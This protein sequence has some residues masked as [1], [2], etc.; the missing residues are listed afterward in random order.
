LYFKVP[1]SDLKGRLEVC[2]AE[3]GKYA[4]SKWLLVVTAKCDKFGVDPKN[5]VA[6]GE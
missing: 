2:A 1:V 3:I 4:A 5:S 6:G